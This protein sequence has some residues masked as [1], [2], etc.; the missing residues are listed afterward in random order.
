[1]VADVWQGIPSSNP[2]SLTNVSGSL[3]FIASDPARGD[4][5]WRSDGSSAGTSLVKEIM[6]THIGP[7]TSSQL[8]NVSGTLFFAANDGSSGDE[9]WKSDGTSAGT[10]M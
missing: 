10:I 1:M 2:R 7:F 9:L 6:P 8:V 4:E 3:F 5:L